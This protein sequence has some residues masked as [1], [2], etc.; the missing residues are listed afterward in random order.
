MRQRM[1]RIYAKNLSKKYLARAQKKKQKKNQC[2]PESNPGPFASNAAALPTLPPSLLVVQGRKT[3]NITK[4]SF[5]A[6]AKLRKKLVFF[7]NLLRMRKKN[8]G[9]ENARDKENS[10]TMCTLANK[11]RLYIISSCSDEIFKDWQK[12]NSMK[13]IFFKKI[14]NSTHASTRAPNLRK[15]HALLLQ[16]RHMRENCA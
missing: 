15:T 10:I 16:T 11:N 6:C 4:A 8:C 5:I 7:A 2:R 13:M 14:A 3:R 12:I 9:K 1:R